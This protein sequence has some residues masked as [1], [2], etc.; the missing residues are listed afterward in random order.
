MTFVRTYWKPMAAGVVGVA[1]GIELKSSYYR[2]AER[3]C[4]RAA[5]SVDAG[6]ARRA[7]L[8]D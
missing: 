2:Q 7:G 5:A 1:V 6:A 8:I 3:N 4:T